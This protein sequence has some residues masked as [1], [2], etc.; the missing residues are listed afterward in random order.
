MKT[1]VPRMFSSI[2]NETS[3]SGNRCSRQPPSGTSSCSAISLASAGWAL[4]VNSF[5]GPCDIARCNWLG[6]KDSNLRIRDPKSRALPLGHAPEN[7]G[8]RGEPPL[9]RR[10]STVANSRFYHGARG[11]FDARRPAATVSRSP[12]RSSQSTSGPASARHRRPRAGNTPKTAEPLPVIAAATAPAASNARTMCADGRMP[13]ARRAPEG[14][15]G[16]ATAPTASPGRAAGAPRAGRSADAS[17]NQRY[18]SAVAMLKSGWTMTSP[19][20]ARRRADRSR[21]RG[22][23]QPPFRRRERTARR[24]RAWPPRAS[25]P[26]ATGAPSRPG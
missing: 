22:R 17:S 21:R 25:A 10:R 18:A 5:S 15:C 6:R 23:R 2:W 1:S 9:A 7:V 19:D 12:R 24:R 13:V 11:R 20:A 4:P 26:R 8:L 14:C 3:L 16:P